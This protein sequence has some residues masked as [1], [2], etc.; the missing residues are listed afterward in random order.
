[1]MYLL[2]LFAL[3]ASL[4][5]AQLTL[6]PTPAKGTQLTQIPIVGLG[7]WHIQDDR[8]NVTDI[9]ATAMQNGYRHFDCAFFYDN[10]KAIGTGIKEGL[11]RTGLKREDVW[12]TS[13]LW[14][15]RCVIWCSWLLSWTEM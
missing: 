5:S 1:M 2:L 10:Q 4:C 3:S 6:P 15:D 14:N 8:S 9:I 7:T 11:R 12:V 13:K